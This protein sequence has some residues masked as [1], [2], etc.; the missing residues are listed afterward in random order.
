M[1]LQILKILRNDRLNQGINKFIKN[2]LGAN[3]LDFPN[4]NLKDIIK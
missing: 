4:L 2:E 1:S 3:Y